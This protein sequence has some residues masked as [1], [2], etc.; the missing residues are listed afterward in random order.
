MAEQQVRELVLE[1]RQRAA[2]VAQLAAQ[3]VRDI[4]LRASTSDID[5]WFGRVESDLL[6]LIAAAFEALRRL[7]AAFL[8]EH[9]ELQGVDL[10]PVLAEWDTDQVRDS[11][12]ITGPVAFKQHMTASGGDVAAARTV[13]ANRMAGSAQRLAMEGERRTVQDTIDESAE[14]VGWRR[15]SDGD[16]CAFCAALIS[17][18]AVYKDARSAG[19]V[20]FGGMPYHDNDGCTAVPL[21]EHEEEPPEVDD[22]YRQWQQV[23]AKTSGDESLRAWRRYWDEN[24]QPIDPEDLLQDTE[25]VAPPPAVELTPEAGRF[26]R[27]LSGIED[28]AGIVDNL[29]DDAER[30]K[31][32]GG[33]SAATSL[34]TGPDGE[35]VVHKRALEFSSDASEV[36]ESV[37]Q[38]SDAEQLASLLG[39]AI[40]A[41]VAR[42]YRN[43]PD[44]VWMEFIADT[45]DPSSNDMFDLLQGADG[46]RLGLLDVLSSNSDRNSGNLLVKDGRLIGI[47][48]GW[49]WGSAGVEEMRQT[50]IGWAD[51]P[52]WHFVNQLDQYARD[53]PLHPDDID[54]LR[55]RLEALRPD[56]DKLGR[57]QWLDY[58][59]MI[60]DELRPHAK[61]T[62]RLYD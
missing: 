22:L 50:V 8:G 1:H 47:D 2:A 43:E 62:E 48:H 29:P 52:I 19:D 21:Y 16:P 51:R 11:L 34:V 44:A 32:S 23:T 36:A 53:N 26:Q 30:T 27:D 17:R 10:L 40:D 33:V 28:L 24:R 39:R 18:G 49:S 4:A 20:R 6:A 9:A 46:V 61:G 55:D 35:R 59:L 57:G 58:S 54:V 14:I 56:F 31:L 38:Q 37:R 45:E 3:Q 12:R 60:L 5:A 15:V 25:T 41:P 7:T 42:V 13:M